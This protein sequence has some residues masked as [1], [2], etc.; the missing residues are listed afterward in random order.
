MSRPRVKINLEI[1]RQLR[2]GGLG[3]RTIARRYYRHTKQDINWMTLRRR[4]IEGELDLAQ[5]QP[6]NNHGNVAL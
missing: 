4:Y 6:G 1:I 5:E 2:K 3:W